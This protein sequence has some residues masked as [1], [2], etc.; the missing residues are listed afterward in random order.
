MHEPLI[1]VIG[2]V[3][4]VPVLRT[5]ANGTSVAGFRIASTRR[6]QDRETGEWS[7]GETLWFGV[8]CWR[9]LAQHCAESLRKG[10]RVVVHGRLVGRS[11]RTDNGEERTGMEID[12]ITVGYDLTRTA[13]A[14]LRS[15]APAAP[16]QEEPP[17]PA[18][19]SAPGDLP[20]GEPLR[21]AA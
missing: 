4:V 19:T 5:V 2:N 15:G 9:T 10:D 18:T 7:D 14:P 11:W 17:A 20:H 1:T 16:D 13:A 21:G 8:T 6:Q 3:G 12:A